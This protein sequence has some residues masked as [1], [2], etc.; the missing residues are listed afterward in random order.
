MGHEDLGDPALFA[1]SL[2]DG[3][4]TAHRGSRIWEIKIFQ[5]VWTL[6]AASDKTN[7]SCFGKWDYLSWI[8]EKSRGGTAFKWMVLGLK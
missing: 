7:P 2:R 4:I 1:L 6:L 3:A 5:S 8:I